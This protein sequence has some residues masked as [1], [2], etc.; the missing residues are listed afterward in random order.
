[1]ESWK[2]AFKLNMRKTREEKG[3]KVVD[4]ADEM[5]VTIAM[6]YRWES[7]AD[8]RIPRAGNIRGICKCLG[9]SSDY[10]LFGEE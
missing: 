6:I 4:L 3:I 8:P 10:L 5:E 9:V 2:E 7:L 1:M